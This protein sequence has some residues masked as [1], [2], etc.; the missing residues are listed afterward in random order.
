AGNFAIALGSMV[1]GA[2]SRHE[3]AGNSTQ[4]TKQPVTAKSLREAGAPE[5]SGNTAIKWILFSTGFCAMAM[6][7][8]W[9]R[10]FTPVLKTQVYS[11]ALVVF[12]YLG[13]TLAG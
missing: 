5:T 11:F 7:V 6:E 3:R 13:A 2:Q 8:V 10:M 1:L 12:V 4:E 9:T